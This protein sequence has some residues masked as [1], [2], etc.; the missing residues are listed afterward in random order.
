MLP[1]LRIAMAKVSAAINPSPDKAPSTKSLSTSV[2]Y[3]IG[4]SFG[5]PPLV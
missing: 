2:S 1:E 3:L 4:P 5:I